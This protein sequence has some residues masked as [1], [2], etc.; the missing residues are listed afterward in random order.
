[1]EKGGAMELSEQLACIHSDDEEFIFQPINHCSYVLSQKSTQS[2]RALCKH[3]KTALHP[4]LVPVS[5]DEN[6]NIMR[7]QFGSPRRHA[8]IV[9]CMFVEEPRFI[10]SYED[11]EGICKDC[12]ALESTME[13]SLHDQDDQHK[14]AQGKAEQNQQ[15]AT[16]SATTKTPSPPPSPPPSLQGKERKAD[17]H[18]YNNNMRC[19]RVRA[20]PTKGTTDGT[21]ET[22]ASFSTHASSLRAKKRKKHDNVKK[23]CLSKALEPNKYKRTVYA[24]SVKRLLEEAMIDKAMHPEEWICV[25]SP[26]MTKYMPKVVSL[27]TATGLSPR[28]IRDYMHNCARRQ[29][30]IV[31]SMATACNAK[32]TTGSKKR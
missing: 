25:R 12:E 11:E 28:Q 5:G 29:R 22:A 3:P 7:H 24:E 2:A 17:E 21:S 27:C 18:Q 23:A 19:L 15:T 30:N 14:M 1:M 16:E 13:Q 8:H 31:A 32:D 20:P 10:V 4:M 9:R 6:P 26:H